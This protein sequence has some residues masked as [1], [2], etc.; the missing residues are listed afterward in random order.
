MKRLIFLFFLVL[1]PLH[2]IGDPQPVKCDMFTVGRFV[3]YQRESLRDNIMTE[4]KVYCQGYYSAW[5][6]RVIT[7]INE[8]KTHIDYDNDKD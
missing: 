5:H 4:Y 6:K 1:S 2:S 3:I 8:T 7:G